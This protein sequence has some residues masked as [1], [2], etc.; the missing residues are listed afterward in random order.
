MN[1]NESL[2][3]KRLTEMSNGVPVAT[4][5][6]PVTTEKL[7][8]IQLTEKAVPEVAKIP[9]AKLTKE[10]QN[11]IVLQ[12]LQGIPVEQLKEII[13]NQLDLEIRLKHKELT[14]TQDE[15][16]K[17]EAQMIVL[18]KFFDVPTD[19]NLSNEPND[20]T[21]RYINTLNKSLLFTFND[22]RNLNK[23]FT[24]VDDPNYNH[25]NSNFV[26]SEQSGHG[27]R[28]RSTTSSLHPTTSAY[29]AGS[30]EPTSATGAVCPSYKNNQ[31]MGCL[32][33]RT[34][35]I[36]V[37][38]TCPDCHRSNFS[39]AQGFLNHSRIA[40]SKEYTSQDAAALKCGEILPAIKQDADGELSLQSLLKKNLD[41]NKNLN[42]NEI[43]FNGLSNTL[44]TVHDS[45]VKTRANS[46][47]DL[48]SKYPAISAK[49]T[50]SPSPTAEDTRQVKQ[51]P[52]DS[53]LLRKLVRESKMKKEEYEKLLEETKAPIANAHLFQNEVEDDSDESVS[54]VFVAESNR[55]KAKRRS[56]RGGI[57]IKNVEGI[58]GE[59]R[60]EDTKEENVEAE[61][62]TEKVVHEDKMET[63][64]AKRRKKQ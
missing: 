41:P 36:V 26:D 46:R 1:I 35:G 12:R 62:S 40:H 3:E 21:M 29:G 64:E 9:K 22:L 43:Y 15:L 23:S 2:P 47:S 56:S 19:L 16:N 52:E 48:V 17:I 24:P 57:N 27:Y 13:S 38:L 30:A 28:T 58:W 32:Y 51:N 39:S 6:L 55:S 14:L 34:D 45:V 4:E 50:T 25:F 31:N 5:E 8:Q 37:R 54:A 63:R 7:P 60:E 33:K 18:R 20:F 44:N 10:E 42:V 59:D 11:N 61:G 53:V 49:S